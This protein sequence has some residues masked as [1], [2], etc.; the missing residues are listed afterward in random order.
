VTHEE[1]IAEHARR[2][3]RL[4]DGRIESDMP[5]PQPLDARAVLAQ[6]PL[7]AEPTS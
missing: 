4:R 1:Q 6:M 2:I 3:V 5:V 7:E